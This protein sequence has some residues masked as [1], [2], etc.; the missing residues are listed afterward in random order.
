LID[1]VVDLYR[2]GDKSI[3][4]KAELRAPGAMVEVDPLRIRQM[5]HNLVKNAQE[6]VAGQAGGMVR[7]ITHR[8]S[9]DDRTFYEM[10]VQDN[11]PGFN[12]EMLQH[13][14]EPYV[15]TKYKGTGLGLAIVKK[16]VEEH[17]GSIWAENCA[18][19]ACLIVQFP[20][21]DAV[22]DKI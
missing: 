8:L 5:V 10:R 20:M 17:G 14:F 11:G 12:Q 15:T 21:L 4:F 18:G 19:G 6:A 9:Q 13:L 1:E 22:E 7:V 16:I 3:D 2:G